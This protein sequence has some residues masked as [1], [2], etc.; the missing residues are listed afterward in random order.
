MMLSIAH[1][2]ASG[3]EPGNTLLAIR[4]A[5]ELDADIIELDVQLTKDRKLVVCHDQKVWVGYKYLSITHHTLETVQ[6]IRLA[7]N[8]HIPSLREALDLINKK[9]AVNIELKDRR[10]AAP[11]CR[12]INEYVSKKRWGYRHFIVSSFIKDELLRIKKLSPRIRIGL[13][14]NKPTRNLSAAIKQYKPYSVHLHFVAVTRD[15]VRELHEQGI[16]VFVWTV[17]SMRLIDRMR[18]YRVDGVFS[19]YPDRI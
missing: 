12:L 1:R 7:K 19:D 13:L 3:Y 10:S 8:Q 18:D 9:A 15:M 11:V 14:Y 4:K 17:N 2:G 6:M 16:K 5:L